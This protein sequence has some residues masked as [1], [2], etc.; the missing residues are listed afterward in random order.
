[1]Q[2]R[3]GKEIAKLMQNQEEWRQNEEFNEAELIMLFHPCVQ[4]MFTFLSTSFTRFRDNVDFDRVQE[5][6][7]L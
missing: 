1:M 5:F 7:L 2:I 6:I 4:M 3:E